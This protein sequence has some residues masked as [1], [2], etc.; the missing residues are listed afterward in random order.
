MA[1]C[2][3]NKWLHNMGLVQCTCAYSNFP[4]IAGTA[5]MGTMQDAYPDNETITGLGSIPD[6]VTFPDGPHS[7]RGGYYGQT[8]YWTPLPKPTLA[9]QRHDAR[10]RLDHGIYQI[11]N[12]EAQYGKY[13]YTLSDWYLNDV[14]H[15]PALNALYADKYNHLPATPQGKPFTAVSVQIPMS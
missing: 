1:K 9:V 5:G 7:P 14:V 12:M 3:N 2:P 6:L 13:L 11:P 15:G 4:S 10:I 8:N